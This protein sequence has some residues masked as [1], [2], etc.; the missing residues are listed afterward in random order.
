MGGAEILESLAEAGFTVEKTPSGS[1]IVSLPRDYRLAGEG[2]LL[3]ARIEGD[4]LIIRNRRDWGVKSLIVSDPEEAPPAIY[5]MWLEA[6]R[7]EARKIVSLSVKAAR[8]SLPTSECRSFLEGKTGV[9]GDKRFCE[10]LLAG[11]T[12]G[13]AVAMTLLGKI[14]SFQELTQGLIVPPASLGETVNAGIV[15]ALSLYRTLA[16]K[17]EAPE[18]IAEAAARLVEEYGW[19]LLYSKAGL[20]L[21][22]YI[23]RIPVS[24]PSI[25]PGLFY[26]DSIIRYIYPCRGVSLFEAG[27]Q[28]ESLWAR[29]GDGTVSC[30]PRNPV[31][32]AMASLYPPG[33][34][35][36]PLIPQ[37]EARGERCLSLGAPECRGDSVV[38]FPEDRGL[39]ELLLRYESGASLLLYY[40]REKLVVA[41]A[42]NNDEAKLGI[43]GIGEDVS[44]SP[45]RAW[46]L[47]KRVKPVEAK[48]KSGA[49]RA[50]DLARFSRLKRV[51]RA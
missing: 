6:Y 35:A 15:A 18:R 5:Y 33:P 30:R 26:V 17:L 45:L 51:I 43:L 47:A 10:H 40:Y 16:P 31:S 9:R 12:Y 22:L 3:D 1:L 37:V 27:V 4:S 44:S 13:L 28:G 36:K 50:E 7:D 14:Y 2:A 41:Y 23:D 48:F 24:W 34:G 11:L 25:M 46:L 32:T 8:K 38:L 20:A 49:V 29:T 21:A 39:Q 19:G 42:R